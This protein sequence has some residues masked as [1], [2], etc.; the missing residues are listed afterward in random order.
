MGKKKP[1]NKFD[2]TQSEVSSVNGSHS[3]YQSIAGGSKL[4]TSDDEYDDDMRFKEAVD[5]IGNKN[6]KV[7]LPALKLVKG[8]MQKEYMITLLSDYYQTLST[9]IYRALKKA[10]VLFSTFNFKNH[11]CKN[12][13]TSRPNYSKR[14][15]YS[16]C[17]LKL[18]M[19]MLFMAMFNAS[20]SI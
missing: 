15:P 19:R 7:S 16:S 2:D 8:Q 11:N 3:T 18:M 10:K 14:W 12:R 9:E 17:R 5:G 4:E 13:A 1:K 20:C 6:S